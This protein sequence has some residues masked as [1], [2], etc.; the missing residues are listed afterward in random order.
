MTTQELIVALRRTHSRAAL[1]RMS[2]GVLTPAKI[3]NLERGRP[4]SAAE[5]EAVRLLAEA[6]PRPPESLEST[7]PPPP[8]EVAAEP[9]PPAVVEVIEP[10]P[11][12]RAPG[13]LTPS[14]RTLLDGVAR[15]SNSEV[16]LFA[17]CRRRWY[18]THVL[19]LRPR[20]ES[21]VGVRQVGDRLHRALQEYYVP[22]GPR[23]PRDVLEQLVREDWAA[24]GDHVDEETALAFRKDADL[25]RVMLDGYVAWLAE[26]GE[27]AE[28]TVVEPEAYLEA[29]L[30]GTDVR[31]IGRIDVRVRRTAPATSSQRLFLD[32]KST[33]S[34]NQLVRFLPM[35][36]Q[37]LHYMLLEQL[38][39]DEQDPVVGAL[40]NIM[41]RV[42][43]TASA[44]PPF[45]VRVE[46][47]H[48]P[49]ELLAFRRRLA[50]AVN[51][52]ELIRAQLE[53]T[54]DH[55]RFAYPRPTQDCSWK[56]PFAQVCPM[57]DDGSRVEAA[58]DDLFV[59]GDPHDYYRPRVAA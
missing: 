58:L 7:P 50:G 51:E 1:Q 45:Y 22:A 28:L 17:D 19:R 54:G 2:G 42:K 52:I 41:R 12:V 31:I 4:P 47:H 37:V 14:E 5:V 36:P 59:V 24:L 46:V 18:L 13:F 56:C 49:V 34:I 40:Y 26:T 20:H 33:G 44:K 15:Y 53:L 10:P 35:H 8:P 32:H 38:Q 57:F 25:E 27:D 39:A 30:P 11:P 43:R 55:L 9:A 3:Y 23:D 21:P 16:Q 29:D 48:S 6:G